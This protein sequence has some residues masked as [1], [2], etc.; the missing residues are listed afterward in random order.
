MN[1]ITSTLL[2]IS[3]L[4]AGGASFAPTAMKRTPWPRTA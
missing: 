3:L 2:S 1:K 4:L